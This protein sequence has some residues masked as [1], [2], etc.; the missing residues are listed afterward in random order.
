MCVASQGLTPAFVRDCQNKWESGVIKSECRC[1]RDCAGHVGYAVMHNSV[2]DISRVGMFGRFRT[3]AATTLVDRH[4]DVNASW[5]HNS[6]HLTT[7]DLWSLR[8]RQE[9]RPDQEVG[10]F[11]Q[12]GD[13]G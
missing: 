6:E 2:D 7:Y 11:H 5:L 3:L 1:P 8:P 4:I 12:L 9:N 13:G 10:P